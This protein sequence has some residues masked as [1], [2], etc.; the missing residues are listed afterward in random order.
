MRGPSN[1]PRLATRARDRGFTLVELLVTISLAGILMSTATWTFLNYQ[2]AHEQKS[3]AV[4]LTSTLRNAA[5]RALSEGRTYCVYVNV[6]A[7]TYDTYRQDCTVPAKRVSRATTDS[8]RVK[9]ASPAFPAPAVPLLT[10]GS[11][12]PVA[13]A[14]AYFYPRGNAL[15]GS[16]RVTRVG[17][18]KVFTVTVEG[19][20]S[21]VSQ[22]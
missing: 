20:T 14:C 22:A 6:S 17:S 7:N 4:E 13:G 16:L 1:R 8:N 5:E 15:A 3:T 9:V 18:S 2:R 11:A 12:C 19:L 21:R 10:Q